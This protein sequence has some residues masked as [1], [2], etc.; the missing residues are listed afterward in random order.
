MEGE[1]IPL[2]FCKNLTGTLVP[3]C[4]SS[5]EKER[6]V[7]GAEKSC[8]RC[9]TPQRHLRVVLGPW[10]ETTPPS[11][12][13]RTAH[14]PLSSNRTTKRERKPVLPPSPRPAT[15]ACSVATP[16]GGWPSFY[17]RRDPLPFQL[18]SLGPAATAGRMAAA[19]GRMAALTDL[20][21]AI[22]ACCCIARAP[23]RR[24]C[25]QKPPLKPRSAW[26]Y[27]HCEFSYCTPPSEPPSHCYRLCS[28]PLLQG[29]LLS[30]R[31][32]GLVVP[33]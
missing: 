18:P 30:L 10:R 19:A 1:V 4:A 17:G 21:A 13:R 9:T 32:L 31:L 23:R 16:G 3:S 14:E 22:Y 25:H 7:E 27:S 6:G 29:V 5:F 8:H 26:L 12:H 20:L 11:R 24:R 28:E 15:V 2:C 33:L